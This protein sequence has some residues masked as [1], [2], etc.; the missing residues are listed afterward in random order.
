MSIQYNYQMMD[1]KRNYINT[2]AKLNGI[3]GKL[4]L[5]K[6]QLVDIY[7][8]VLNSSRMLES[9]DGKIDSIT[10]LIKVIDIKIDGISRQVSDLSSQ[11]VRQTLELTNEIKFQKLFDFMSDLQSYSY[12]SKQTVIAYS[13]N[14][15]ALLIQLDL[16]ADRYKRDNLEFKIVNYLD[17]NFIGSKSLIETYI[18]MISLNAL[19]NFSPVSSSIGKMIDEFYMEIFMMIT[20]G[21]GF[22]DFYYNLRRQIVDGENIKKLPYVS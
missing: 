17:M 3:D 10:G 8:N 2:L 4:D 7:G 6:N 19:D 20:E 14:S 21:F 5:V 9:I 18:D 15:T 11:I 16:L 12:E 1:S 13:S 22:Y